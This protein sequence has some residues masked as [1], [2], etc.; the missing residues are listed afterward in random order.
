V[1]VHAANAIQK[2]TSDTV[3]SHR[4]PVST[5]V[6]YVADEYIPSGNT[7]AHHTPGASPRLLR[8][9]CSVAQISSGIHAVATHHVATVTGHTLCRP[10]LWM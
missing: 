8:K 4:H 10:A 1:T 6:A 9:R 5:A 3:V 7:A 2:N